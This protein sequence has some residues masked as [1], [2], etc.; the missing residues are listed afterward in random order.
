MD[1]FSTPGTLDPSHSSTMQQPSQVFRWLGRFAPAFCLNGNQV[2]IITEPAAYYEFLESSMKTFTRRAVL[3]ALYLGTGRL[4][5]NLVSALQNRCSEL[6]KSATPFN[7]HFLLDYQRGSRGSK[8]SRTILLPL[9]QENAERVKLSL[10]HTPNLRGIWKTH[11][12]ERWNEI[13]GLLHMK[14]CVF[15]DNVLITGANLSDQYFTNRQDRYVLIKNVPELANFFEELVQGVAGA[16]F[17]VNAQDEVGLSSDTAAHPYLGSKEDF[18]EHAKDS[19]RRAYSM[20][21]PTQ[22]FAAGP[23]VSIDNAD[24]WI[25]PLVQMKHFDVLK[26]EKATEEILS[27]VPEDTHIHLASGY[28]NLTRSYRRLILT[29]PQAHYSILMASPQTNGFFGAEGASSAVPAM[30]VQIA[31]TFFKHIQRHAQQHR[32]KLYEYYRDGWTY[33]VKGLWATLPG[34]QN[35]ALTLVGSPN[36]GYRS[37]NRDIEAQIAVVTENADLQKR[38]AEERDRLFH[39]GRYITDETFESEHHQVPWSVRLSW[40]W[41][42]NFF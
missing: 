37:V 20:Y 3:S 24:T 15:D 29:Q 9:L 32:V 19:V 14:V 23:D 11:V 38:L 2:S 31:K 4:E 26:D 35:P 27:S 28:F 25:Y 1:R 16:S 41:I 33:H 39:D 34:Q 42:K 5:Q 36:F 22:R 12:P 10:F 6:K 17:T 13:V 21:P 7:V 18:I 8:N 40:R 30:Y